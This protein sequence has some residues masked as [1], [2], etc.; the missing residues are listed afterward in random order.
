MTE[1]DFLITSQFRTESNLQHTAEPV[2]LFWVH[3][4]HMISD[5]CSILANILKIYPYF[6]FTDSSKSSGKMRYH[7]IQNMYCV[8]GL[9]I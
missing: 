2:V 4:C 7:V 3:F 1:I 5:L 6:D 9:Q 8:R